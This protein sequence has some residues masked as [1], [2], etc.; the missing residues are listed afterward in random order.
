VDGGEKNSRG[1]Q[2]WREK[3]HQKLISATKTLDPKTADFVHTAVSQNF[4]KVVALLEVGF[5]LTKG[6]KISPLGIKLRR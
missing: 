3:G 1:H 5:S 2:F 4:D 6:K